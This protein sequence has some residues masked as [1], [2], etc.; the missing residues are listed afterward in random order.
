MCALV[1]KSGANINYLIEWMLVG[2]VFI[3]KAVEDA[4]SAAVDRRQ[5]PAFV[6]ALPPVALGMAALF[7]GL[8]GQGAIGSS[9]ARQQRLR[10]FEQLEAMVRAATLPVISDDMVV[11]L[12]GGKEVVWEPA[13]FAELASTGVW[14]ERPFVAR[15]RDRRF[16]FFV[17]EGDWG[18]PE[19]DSR[20]TPA[21]RSAMAE[22]YPRKCQLGNYV[23]HLPTPSN[24]G[25]AG[26]KTT[27]GHPPLPR[28]SPQIKLS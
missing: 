13:I 21:V 24:H 23:I 5:R 27:V 7:N 16:G 2:A 22:A 15:I 26:Q 14:D 12:R 3:G 17:T 19:F 10:D 11:V 8:S 25:P 6:A 20:Y 1:A 28:C 18:D 4:A 9:P